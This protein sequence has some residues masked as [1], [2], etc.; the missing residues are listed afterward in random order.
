MI[1]VWERLDCEN[2]G[3]AEIKAITDV[4]RE[5]FGRSAVDGPMTIA[6]L[7]A[8][9][10]AE[11]RHSEIMELHVE[12]AGERP[13]DAVFRNI[14]DTSDLKRSR[15]SIRRMENLR[16]KFVSDG[17]KEGIRLLTEMA[18]AGVDKLLKKE[19]MTGAQNTY[20]NEIAEWFRIWIGSP[21]VFENW[22]RIRVNS[23][24]FLSKFG[25]LDK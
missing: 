19:K 10:G 14:L 1:E 20:N 12:R 18:R 16:R 11:L 9:E 2:V 6:R 15:S 3:A 25:P 7:L 23:K 8:D 13:Y 22:I 4:I 24:D 21:E 5:R 17:D